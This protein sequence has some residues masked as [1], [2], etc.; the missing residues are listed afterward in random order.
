MRHGQKKIGLALGSGGARGWA[1]I[2][3]LHAVQEMGLPIHCVAGTSMG[4]AVG[5][6]YVSGR[7]D[8]LHHVALSLNWQRLLYYFTDLSFPRAGLIDGSRIVALVGEHVSAVD[9]QNLP[10][11]FAAV[12]TDIRAGAEVVFSEGSVL[13]AV[14]ASIA[15][16]GVFTPLM[17]DGA[18]LVDGGLV[19]PLPVSVA[20]AMGADFVIA[21]DVTEEPG[22]PPA[23]GRKMPSA[24][25]ATDWPHAPQAALSEA[26]GQWLKRIDRMF[27]SVNRSAPRSRKERPGPDALPNIFDIY[28]NVIR[29]VERQILAMRLKLEPPDLLIRPDIRGIGTMDFHKAHEAIRAGYDAARVRLCEAAEQGPLRKYLPGR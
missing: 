4:A 23:R 1:H 28:A 18:V 7:I 2:G 11:R 26:L 22:L 20:R 29:I 3:A 24:P 13:D 25:D 12:A 8:D 16:P 6:A 9:I 14:R 17:K 15:I 10:M 21:V 19:N 5:A 27:R